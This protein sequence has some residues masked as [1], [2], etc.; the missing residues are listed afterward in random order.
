MMQVH[1][2]PHQPPTRTTSTGGPFRHFPPRDFEPFLPPYVPPRGRWQWIPDEQPVFRC[3]ACANG[4]VCMCV[5]PE[6]QITCF[7]S[8]G[9]AKTFTMVISSRSTGSLTIG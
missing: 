5:R 3:P 7:D 4:G 9:P 2:L 1:P 8:N 6:R